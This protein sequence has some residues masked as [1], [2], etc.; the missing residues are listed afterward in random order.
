MPHKSAI[1]T[2]RL[3]VFN[4]TFA[5]LVKAKHPS[6]GS[7][8]VAVLWH[9]GTAGRDAPPDVAATYWRFLSQ[10]GDKEHTTVY[11]DNC[12]AQNKCWIFVTM[13]VTY[14]QQPE[15]VTRDITIKYLE[16]G[17][18]A[19]SADSSHQVIQ[20]KL[21]RV[22]DIH[23]FQDFVDL[24]EGSGVR[25]KV[26]SPEEFFNFED[27]VSR[28]KL[29]LLGQEGLRPHLRD[30]RQLQVR[31]GSE[32]IYIKKSHKQQSWTGYDLFRNNYDPT[33][34]PKRRSEPRG[35]NKDK[36]EAICRGLTPLVPSHKA[37]FWH[38]LQS[39]ASRAGVR[40]LTKA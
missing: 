20:K 19:M 40:D 17:H 10:H 38:Q 15:N 24:V 31:R 35:V 18:T 36:V 22:K 11:A 16:T 5:P 26:M 39:H 1:F 14:V 12:S 32:R 28:S 8:A 30:V 23:D 25:V 2:P 34:P 29:G 27:G 3:I 7:V 13:L 9:E 21:G 33:E 37:L 4:V 6:G